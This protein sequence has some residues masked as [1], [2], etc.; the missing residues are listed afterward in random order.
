MG[1]SEQEDGRWANFY[2][3]VDI[4]LLF[5]ELSLPHGQVLRVLSKIDNWQFDSFVLSEV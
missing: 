1:A 4:E 5:L 3:R 2:L